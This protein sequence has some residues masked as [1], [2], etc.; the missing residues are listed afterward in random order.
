[1]L[2]AEL[3]QRGYRVRALIR[4]PDK[5]GELS[6]LGVTLIQ[7]DLDDTAALKSLVADTTAV[8]H[9]AGAV[10][11]SCQQ[12]FD[13]INVAGTGRLLAAIETLSQPPRL[14]LLS[15][16]TAREA[17]LSWYASSK[18]RSEELLQSH[19]GIDWLILRPPAVYGPGDKE[20]LPVFQAMSRGIAPVPG[21]TTA[22]ISLIH[23]ND[24][25]TAAI[26]CLE[27]NATRHQTLTLCD[28]RE[29]GYNWRDMA[30]VA[31][32]VWGR[33]VRLW[34]VPPWL[35]DCVA[36][37]NVQSARLT[38]RAPM[39]TPPKLRELRHSDWVVGNEAIAKMT[40]WQPEIG[41]QKGLEMLRKAEI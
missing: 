25:V 40:S 6:D 26:T 3:L 22:R 13:R 37:I 14:L 18:Y 15:S 34:Q 1:V 32:I 36:W 41:L 27:S 17:E 23:V 29:N 9:A 31:G 10:R 12:D 19:S 24:L 11:G 38:G 2:C 16:L 4:N 21:K 8:I 20:M 39:L 5:A 35:L 33:K 28:G 30:D 7:G